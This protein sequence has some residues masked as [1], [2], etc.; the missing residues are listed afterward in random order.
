MKIEISLAVI[1][2]LLFIVNNVIIHLFNWWMRYI[3]KNTDNDLELFLW[4]ISYVFIIFINLI[5]IVTNLN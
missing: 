3:I 4:I 2:V 1:F 5:I